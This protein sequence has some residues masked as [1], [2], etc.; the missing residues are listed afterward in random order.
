LLLFLVLVEYL[1]RTIDPI[2]RPLISIR[3]ESSTF[4]LRGDIDYADDSLRTADSIGEAQSMVDALFSAMHGVDL[5][6]NP[7]KLRSLGLVYF[8]ATD[9]Q[10]FDPRLKARGVDGRSKPI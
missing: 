8:E 6:E 9:I 3:G 2:H 4:K 7:R 5:Q 10:V 1:R